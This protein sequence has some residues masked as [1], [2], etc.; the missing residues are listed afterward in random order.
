MGEASVVKWGKVEV[1]MRRLLTLFLQD[2]AFLLPW[3]LRPFLHRGRGVKIGKNVYIGSLVV[4]DDAFPEYIHIGDNVQISAGAKIAT[5]DSSMK[6]AFAG[7]L[8]THICPVI[9]ERNAYIGS[10]AIILP[11]V[12]IGQSAVVGAGAV[13]TSDVPPRTVVVGVPAKPIG[14]VD[15]KI[16]RF[17]TKDGLFQWKYYEK[18]RKLSDHEVQ[19]VKRNLKQGAERG[20]NS[21]E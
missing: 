8:P 21:N 17:L 4:L 11:G 9:I 16:E 2:L 20:K 12:T 7:K 14:T 13:V 1:A 5:H 6:N 18:P 10:G 19:R 15:D 3:P